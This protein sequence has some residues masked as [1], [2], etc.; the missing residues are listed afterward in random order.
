LQVDVSPFIAGS[1]TSTD[2]QS[3]IRPA[4]V[5]IERVW[6]AAAWSEAQIGQTVP[7]TVLISDF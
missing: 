4:E 5:F 3:L 6:D 2:T 1:T 7:M